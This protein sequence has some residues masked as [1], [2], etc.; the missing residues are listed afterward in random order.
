MKRYTRRTG[1]GKE[2]LLR[3]LISEDKVDRAINY[4]TKTG[5]HHKD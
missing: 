4:I 1:F 5:K 3:K 2:I